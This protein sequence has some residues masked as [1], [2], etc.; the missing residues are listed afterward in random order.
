MSLPPHPHNPSESASQ[1]DVR[2]RAA[3]IRLLITDVDGV[4]TDGSITYDSRGN[5]LK[6]FYV[7]DGLGVKSWQQLGFVIGIITGRGGE[8]VRKRATE[9]G[10]VHLSEQTR[11]KA[12]DLRAMAEQARIPLAQT[13]YIG[14]DWPDLPALRICGY[15]MAVADAHP[16]IKSMAAFTT[17]APGGRGAL[18]EAIE[19]LLDARSML[20]TARALY[21]T[22]Q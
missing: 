5:E 15:P 6:T 21:D 10:I 13:A 16:D 22:N 18:R 17:A 19:H 8:P 2:A 11:D 9:L 4:L 20:C 1:S 12:A 14:D 3:T 7:R